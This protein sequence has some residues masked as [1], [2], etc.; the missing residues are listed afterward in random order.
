MTKEKYPEIGAWARLE[1][2]AQIARNDPDDKHSR[3]VVKRVLLKAPA[4]GQFVGVTYLYEGRHVPG[5]YEDPG[6][7]ADRRG[8]M[9]YLVRL[10]L[11]SKPVHVLPDD[12]RPASHEGRELPFVARPDYQ[13]DYAY[14][15]VREPRIGSAVDQPATAPTR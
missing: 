13:L 6:Y 5:G 14:R 15:K 3:R 7:L 11:R 9:V 4:I 8:V 1:A 12:F 2:L 10:G